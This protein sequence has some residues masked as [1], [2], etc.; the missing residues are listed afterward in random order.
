[1]GDSREHTMIEHAHYEEFCALLAIGEISEAELQYL[2]SHLA[3][4]KG[5]RDRLADFSQLSAQVIP[6]AGERYIPV[7]VPAGMTERFHESARRAGF[8]IRDPLF[9]SIKSSWSRPRMLAAVCCS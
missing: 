7:A 9:K 1:M 4:C 5:C 6:I 8:P 3:D 2:R